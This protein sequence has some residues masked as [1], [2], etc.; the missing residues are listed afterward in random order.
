MLLLPTRPDLTA[1]YEAFAAAL[2][3]R[4]C[5]VTLVGYIE[6]GGPLDS[7]AGLLAHLRDERGSPPV[8]LCGHGFGGLVAVEYLESAL[9]QPDFALL[10][11][12]ALG[13]GQPRSMLGRL[14]RRAGFDAVERVQARVA[15]GFDRVRV[16]TKIEHGSEDAVT[17]PRSWF[18]W[19]R[20]ADS[21]LDTVV[22]N[23]AG[24]DLPNEPAYRTHIDDV[25]GW[26]IRSS[27]TR[28][29]EA[30]PPGPDV[31][32]WERLS[33]GEATAAFE[34][35]VASEEERVRRFRAELAR[36][37]GPAP[38]ASGTA[39]DQLGA[40][41]LDEVEAGPRAGD[42]PDWVY[43]GAQGPMQRLSAASLW[44][45]DGAAAHFAASLREL[46]PDLRWELCTQ[47]VNAYYHRVVLEPIGLQSRLLAGALITQLRAVEPDPH[48]LG[49]LWEVWLRTLELVRAN[50]GG[51][52]DDPLPLDEISVDP[53]DHPRLNAQIWIPEGAEA[54]LGERRFER[55]ADQI[56][57]LRGV[58]E[59]VWE[60]RE[61]M[62]IRLAPGVD[63][64]DLRK[65]IVGVVRRAQR[66]ADADRDGDR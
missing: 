9:P 56:R 41:L 10:L 42:L 48:W 3:D 45:I 30:M 14:L 54:V 24:H 28:W 12:P 5:S 34:A 1:G 13:S 49:R 2:A 39:M 59:L 63:H 25:T 47:R 46:E 26:L 23:R 8:V 50:P 37:G 11:A 66:A 65:R 32:R 51:A 18:A 27:R 44:L 6:P 20:M 4:G 35:F 22:I 29:P 19:Q 36:R 43:R 31:D 21:V 61:V 58:E 33:R 55:L 60:D 40:W 53:Y 7:V 16:R 17:P 62:L 57:R 64:G 38:M 15:A 52:D